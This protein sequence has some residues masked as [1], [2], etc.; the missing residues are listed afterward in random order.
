MIDSCW[1]TN[2]LSWFGVRELTSELGFETG[3]AKLSSV[4]KTGKGSGTK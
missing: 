3:D 2:F 4:S 1:L